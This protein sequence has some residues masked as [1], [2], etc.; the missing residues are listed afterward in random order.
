VAICRE[1]PIDPHR[2]AHRLAHDEWISF[3]AFS[4]GNVLVLAR[5]L[6]AYRHHANNSSKESWTIANP[7]SRLRRFMANSSAHLE[8][9]AES[10]SSRACA[11]EAIREPSIAE[12]RLALVQ[13]RARW[14]RLAEIE[15]QRLALWSGSTLI[16]RLRAW[17]NV[18]RNG[19]YRDPGVGSRE[20]AKDVTL[21]IGGIRR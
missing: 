15:R 6:A 9:I 17:F 13:A 5:P 3:L 10:A 20:L 18:V 19:G 12:E 16:Q 2:P 21:G 1:R 8:R 4:L 14:R 7:W 11:L